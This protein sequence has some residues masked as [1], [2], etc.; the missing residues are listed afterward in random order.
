[1]NI[2]SP[3]AIHKPVIYHLSIAD[4]IY[5]ENS[6]S[7]FHA[8]PMASQASATINLTFGVGPDAVPH[9]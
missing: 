9:T 6:I 8:S 7:E 4:M 5:C 1:M 3:Y 2:Y